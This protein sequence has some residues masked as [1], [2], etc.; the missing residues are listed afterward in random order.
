MKLNVIKSH[1][2]LFLIFLATTTFAQ[3]PAIFT[4]QDFQQPIEKRVADLLSRMTLEEKVDLLSGKGN[5]T[6][7]NVRLGIPQFVITDGP[8]GDR[9]SVV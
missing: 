3:T 8:M 7:P 9:K 2:V 6:K 1:V 4:Y 5:F